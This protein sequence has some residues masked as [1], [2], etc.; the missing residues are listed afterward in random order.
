M[1]NKILV[2]LTLTSL[3]LS[4]C[5]G[6]P[7]HVENI[8]EIIKLSIRN[9][10]IIED[11]LKDNLWI[12]TNIYDAGHY[13][14]IPLE[15]AFRLNNTQWKELFS[16][17]FQRFVE[18]HNVANSTVDKSRLNYLHYLY[19]TSRFVS[20]AHEYGEID[21]IPEGLEDIIY[22][23]IISIYYI[24]EAWQWDREHFVNM[25][26]RLK[27]KLDNK[28]VEYSYYRAI[29]DEELFTFA[30]A[31]NLRNSYKDNT[32]DERLSKIDSI[33]KTAYI[34]F[35]Q[36]SSFSNEGNW[37]FQVGVW[38][39]HTDYKYVGNLE[40]SNEMNPF[41]MD[42][43]NTDSSHFSRFPL[44][45]RDFI[46]VYEKESIER[47]LFEKIQLGL[48]KQFVEKVLI[49]PSEDFNAYRLNN[50][51]NGHNGIYRWNYPTHDVSNGYGPYELSGTFMLGWWS[52]LD[53]D[54]V[55]EAY[56][57]MSNIFPLE[58]NIIDI[59]T[60]PNTSRERN[61]YVRFPDYLENGFAE[62]ICS[63]IV[64]MDTTKSLKNLGR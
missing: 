17:H 60:G 5:A 8:D 14:Q 20:L 21:L 50:F 31:T 9:I 43:I 27:W 7:V 48:T 62:L 28:D 37:L 18:D 4:G 47:D 59:Y 58:Q 12:E 13:L 38:R 53:S 41:P 35:K 11:Y 19:L 26:E 54:E 57:Y 63:L 40:K 64:E 1:I 29:I 23:S 34:V 56:K 3:L 42:D 30:I 32:N 49:N 45:I 16:N 44:F 55:T 24:E 61:K 52:F 51:M 36:E 39:D 46:R 25:E 10:D 33:L 6:N 2:W 15:A 22:D